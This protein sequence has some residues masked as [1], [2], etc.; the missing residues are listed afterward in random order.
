MITECSNGD[1]FEGLNE[2]DMWNGLG[3]ELLADGG[4]YEGNWKEDERLEHVI[5]R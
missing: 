5:H 4:S 1:K 3:R 2:N